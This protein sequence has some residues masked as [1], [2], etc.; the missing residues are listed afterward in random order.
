MTILML[1]M[2]ALAYALLWG[3]VIKCT[4]IINKTDDAGYTSRDAI[5]SI[6]KNA[7]SRRHGEHTAR[8]HRK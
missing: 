1:I 5:N 2:I 4:R 8:L 6:S 7:A 3:L